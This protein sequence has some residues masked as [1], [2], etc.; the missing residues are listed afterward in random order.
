M[1]EYIKNVIRTYPKADPF[2]YQLLD[3][4][5]QDCR[6]FLGYGNRHR[7]Y[8]WSLNEKEQIHNMRAL[9][10]SFPISGKPE[11][12]TLADMARYEKEMCSEEGVEDPRPKGYMELHIL[13]PGCYGE[14]V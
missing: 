2:K 7:K 5:L 6:Y 11:W 12:L 8:L 1:T 4:M 13:P 3:R 9:W 14:L 10:I